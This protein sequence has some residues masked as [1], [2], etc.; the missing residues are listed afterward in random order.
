M[1]WAEFSAAFGAFFLSHSIPVRPRVK[2][3]LSARLGRR[4]FTLG[5]SL[6]SLAM[7][8]WVIGAAG[9]APFVPLWDWAAWQGQVTLSLML[10]VCMILALAIGRP[11]P[12]SFGGAGNAGF[13][14]HRPGIVRVTRHPLLLALTL[15]SVGHVLPNGDLAHVILF[16]IFAGFALVGGTVI[17]RRKRRAMAAEWARLDRARRQMWPR[18]HN[19]GRAVVRAALGLLLYALLL[20]AHPYLFGVAPLG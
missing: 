8:A 10:A 20:W 3:W 15:W 16:G 9:R 13:D 17:D 19:L 1:G 5:Y 18:P 14:P 4:G 12:F 11:N 7:L 6:L 2:T